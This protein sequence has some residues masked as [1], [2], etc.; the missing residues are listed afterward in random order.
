MELMPN[1]DKNPPTKIE[2]RVSG[3]VREDVDDGGCTKYLLLEQH[4]LH[5]RYRPKN[6]TLAI[7]FAALCSH[8][9]LQKFCPQLSTV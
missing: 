7:P 9:P 6:V 2:C 3:T 5:K 8:L 1:V 4:S